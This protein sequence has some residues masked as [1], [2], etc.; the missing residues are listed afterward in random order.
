MAVILIFAGLLW[1]PRRT[2]NRLLPFQRAVWLVL[3]AGGIEVADAKSRSRIAWDAIAQ[4]AKGRRG[5]L[6]RTNLGGALF[7]PLR[8]LDAAGRERLDAWLRWHAAKFGNRLPS[9]VRAAIVLWLVLIALFV[10]F[11]F[12]FVEGSATRA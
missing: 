5:V 11:Y 3:D 1:S 2:F 9:G 12:V 8:V 7:L 10:A 6:F 4:I